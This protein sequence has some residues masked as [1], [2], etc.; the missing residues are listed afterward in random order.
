MRKRNLLI[1]CA[2]LSLSLTTVPAFAAETES[3]TEDT[4]IVNDVTTELEN[5]VLTIR[6]ADSGELQS[7]PGFSWEF[8]TGDMGDAPHTELLTQS[9]MEDGYVYA[10]SFR[11]TDDGEGV[12]RLVETNGHYVKQYMDFNVKVEDEM[13][14]ETLGGGQAYETA[15]EDL[16]PYLEGTWVEEGETPRRMDISLT[17]DGGLSFVI[18]NGDDPEA[19][20][21]T[22]TAYY[23]CIKGALVYWDGVEAGTET[24]AAS[25]SETEAEDG[26]AG[27]G[28]FIIDVVSDASDDEMAFG[29]YWSDESFGNEA[30]EI[31][32]KEE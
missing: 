22:M 19:A 32:L 29:I 28:M 31:F 2:I 23:D 17:E 8:W 9:D 27:T 18:S 11:G 15:G 21:Y 10:G 26:T 24:E 20:S 6:I 30:E 7:D 4:G 3:G 14:T 12:I 5:G 25:G 1:G 13:I 16:A